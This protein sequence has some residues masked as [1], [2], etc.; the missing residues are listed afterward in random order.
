MKA[1]CLFY[2][3]PCNSMKQVDIPVPQ[4]GDS[5]VAQQMCKEDCEDLAKSSCIHDL[6]KVNNC[7]TLLLLYI[8]LVP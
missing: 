8:S 3:E 1:L 2:Y 4:S 5:M 7:F 6:S